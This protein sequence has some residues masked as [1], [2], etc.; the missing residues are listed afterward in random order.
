MAPLQVR[1]ATVKVECPHL[2]SHAQ[3]LPTLGSVLRSHF[4]DCR[5][6]S[7]ETPP[8][9]RVGARVSTSHTMIPDS[10]PSTGRP[11][12]GFKFRSST[13]KPITLSNIQWWL[14]HQI[15][16]LHRATECVAASLRFLVQRFH[17]LPCHK[18]PAH[19]AGAP[20]V[21]RALE[22]DRNKAGDWLSTHSPA[23]QPQPWDVGI[24]SLLCGRNP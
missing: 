1:C 15:S 24:L 18:H 10:D 4:T 21:L 13:S 19:R 6:E 2:L 11:G 5:M 12:P 20:A 8:H 23:W 17:F 22:G 3:L 7:A 16:V 14:T 9:N